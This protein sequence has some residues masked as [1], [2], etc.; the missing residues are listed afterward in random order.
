M[1]SATVP[2]SAL[3]PWESA[4]RQTGPASTCWRA[5]GVGRTRYRELGVHT[6]SDSA[7]ALRSSDRR[8]DRQR[9]DDARF[10][11]FGGSRL[12]SARGLRGA[13]QHAHRRSQPVVEGVGQ[14]RVRRVAG[15]QRRGRSA[16]GRDEV[17]EALHPASERLARGARGGERDRRLRAGVYFPT[18]YGDDQVRALREVAVT[19][20]SPTPACAAI[21]RTAASTPSRANTVIAAWRRAS[22][23]RCASARFFG[24]SGIES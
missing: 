2:A 12:S 17:S 13:E 4:A 15:V 22:V 9:D 19:V 23:L 10:P 5:A 20:P 6:R 11:R 14:G 21:C 24:G 7:C 16:L 3:P 1:T 18:K 8:S